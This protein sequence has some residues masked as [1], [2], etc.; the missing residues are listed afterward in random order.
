MLRLLDLLWKKMQFKCSQPMATR[1]IK[2]TNLQAMKGT[3]S[4]YETVPFSLNGIPT[5]LYQIL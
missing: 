2:V 5:Y 3:G 1:I 4:M